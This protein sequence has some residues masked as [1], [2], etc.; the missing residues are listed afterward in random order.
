MPLAPSVPDGDDFLQYLPLVD[1]AIAFV[2]RR[3]CL[4]AEEAEDFASHVRLKLFEDDFAILR[5]CRH[6]PIR[7]SYL[8]V[9]ISRLLLDYRIAQWGK[10]RPSAEARRRGP[11]AELLERLVSRDGFTF[12]EAFEILAT[13][14]RVSL[15]RV[16]LERI[17]ALLPIRSKRRFDSEDVLAATAST[18]PSPEEALADRERGEK[19]ERVSR[20]LNRVVAR[21]EPEDGLI[22]MLHFR[23]GHSV[24]EIASL[25]RLP[26]KPLYRRLERIL[27]R[28]RAA[29]AGEGFDRS[30]ISEL[31]G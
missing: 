1:R 2:A 29:L 24:T 3:K 8:T 25:L 17:A 7:P 4:S 22:L 23:D 28:L 14:Y 11:V 27:A 21:L 13:N 30:A 20:A 6:R 10:W 5:K 12:E 9:V 19:A 31:L 16:E 26:Q 18:E 15:D